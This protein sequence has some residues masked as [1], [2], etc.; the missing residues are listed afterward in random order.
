MK[1]L[2]GQG[3]FGWRLGVQLFFGGAC[4]SYC[5]SFIVEEAHLLFA[6]GRTIIINGCKSGHGGYTIMNVWVVMLGDSNLSSRSNYQKENFSTKDLIYCIF[7]DTGCV[8]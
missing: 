8:F 5:K 7:P 4:W 1:V 3:C 2:H 6:W